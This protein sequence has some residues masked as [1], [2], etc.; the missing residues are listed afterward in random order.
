MNIAFLTPEY[1]H[2]DLSRSG[3][4]GTSIKNLATG[5]ISKNVTVTVFVVGQVEHKEIDDEG[6]NIVVFAKKKHIA[7]NCIDDSVY[8]SFFSIFYDDDF[9]ACNNHELPV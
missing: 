3:G 6:I 1:P 4:L 8:V 5:L 9:K 2:P 7:L